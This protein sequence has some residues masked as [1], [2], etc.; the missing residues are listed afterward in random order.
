[1]STD[2]DQIRADIERTRS[3]L[4]SDVDAL[5]DKV[6]PSSIVDRQTEKVKDKLGS[7]RD[8][9]MGAR[10]DAAESVRDATS[11]TG[12]GVADVKR[13]AVRTAKGNPLAVGLIAFGLGA[14]VASLV[15][16]SE[17]EKQATGKVKDA[18][19]PLV[20]EVKG[21]A[22]D[23][24]QELKE[25]AADAVGSVRETTMD[26]A[27]HVKTDAQ[28][29]TETVKGDAQSAADSVKSDATSSAENVRDSAQEARDNVQGA[30]S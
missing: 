3:T 15:P 16:A 7:V 17:P 26:A 10:D 14:L 1:M 6:T 29:A 20:D 11:A 4:G 30:G 5:A 22:Q 25:P 23:L 18:A 21:A 8:S 9:I 19:E 24:A 27:E 12:D 2:P 28:S 13:Q